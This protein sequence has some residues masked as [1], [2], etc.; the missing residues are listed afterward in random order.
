MLLQQ[1][2]GEM[3]QDFHTDPT[4]PYNM[5]AFCDYSFLEQG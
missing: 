3:W 1:K 4:D 2:Y 5:Y